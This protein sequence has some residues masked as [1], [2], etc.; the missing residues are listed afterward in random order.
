MCGIA[1]VINNDTYGTHTDDYMRD[2]MLAS[3]VRGVD[4]AGMFQVDRKGEVSLHKT[5]TNAS[6][7][8]IGATAKNMIRTT[9]SS[10]L[11][12]GH[13]RAA[14]MGGISANNAHPFHI[15]RED[16]TEV[17]GVHNGTLSNWRNKPESSD[18][19]VDSE[20]AF[21]MIAKHGS[22]AFEYF[23]GA[24]AFVW[25][26]STY[27]DSVFM[28]RN[29]ERP[30]H[31]MV[32]YWGHSILGCSELG[33]LRWVAG[34][35]SFKLD[36]KSRF[37]TAYYL[38]EG[39]I[40]QFSL[41]NIGEIRVTD[42]PAHDPS[43]TLASTVVQFPVVVRSHYT[44]QGI[45]PNYTRD[46]MMQDGWVNDEWD[47]S[48]DGY[49]GGYPSSYGGVDY[50]LIDQEETLEG[51]K[52][53]IREARN[54]DWRLVKRDLE[55]EDDGESPIEGGGVD[56]GDAV[57]MDADELEKAMTQAID[58]HMRGRE[59]P[60]DIV[61][62]HAPTTQ[63]DRISKGGTFLYSVDGKSATEREKKSAKDAGMYGMVVNFSGIDYDDDT[64]VCLGGFTIQRDGQM[65][66][67]YEGEIRFVPS[68]VANDLYIQRN[69]LAIVV[70]LDVDAQW[71]VLERLSEEMRG[72][73]KFHEL[74]LH[75]QV[76]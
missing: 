74:D 48:D 70:G 72:F 40:Y 68:K 16:G 63:E 2:A 28:A 51:V 32:D 57:L 8:L 15:E 1:F 23:D 21:H 29:K 38:E 33:M 11:T 61:P 44:Q 9:A 76:H 12:V 31:Y 52:A 53:A 17:V 59:M 54:S 27:P 14:T 47:Y 64:S 26:D 39:K 3:Q 41:K 30:L 67:N 60:A 10:R 58:E 50:D 25:Y 66:E 69:G 4:S 49:T 20:W 62:W 7:F 35:N 36:E 42:Y 46:R 45:A 34:R 55:D 65:P 19:T 5:G 37:P 56:P 73:V 6:N 13:V 75:T 43:N 22:K 71:L 24:F 18:F